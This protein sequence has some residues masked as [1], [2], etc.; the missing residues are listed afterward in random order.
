MSKLGQ[1]S[2][3]HCHRS[4]W[5]AYRTAQGQ[6]W[7]QVSNAFKSTALC[8]NQRSS[9]DVIQRGA[10]NRYNVFAGDPLHD[11]EKTTMSG[12]NPVAIPAT[13]QT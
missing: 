3:E 11:W 6:D 7:N 2:A 9:V 12:K 4:C 10:C 8:L 13:H 1:C 5:I